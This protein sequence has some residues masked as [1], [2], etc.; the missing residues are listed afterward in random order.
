[1]KKKQ[2][3]RDKKREDEVSK[4]HRSSNDKTH[5]TTEKYIN[6]TNS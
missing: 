5:S 4:T 6:E 3:K 2:M 1:M